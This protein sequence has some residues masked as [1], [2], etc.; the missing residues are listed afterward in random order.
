M[1]LGGKVAFHPPILIV[2]VLAL[3]VGLSVWGW[4]TVQRDVSGIPV[5]QSISDPMRVRPDNP[6]GAQA[7]PQGLSVNEVQSD[8]RA[9][10][11]V[12]QVVLAPPPL[13][14][15]TNGLSNIPQSQS[16][17]SSA[18]APLTPDMSPEQQKAALDAMAAA[19][20]AGIS[21]LE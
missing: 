15:S 11:P 7:D 1:G 20:A 2:P 16:N 19:L 3:V 21:P 10:Q 9:G 14:L 6:G 18:I 8:G 13:D 4:Q 5:I 17:G 12:E